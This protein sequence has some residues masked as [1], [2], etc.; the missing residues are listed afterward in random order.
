MEK[1]RRAVFVVTYSK[2]SEGIKYLVLKRKLHWKGWEFPKEGIEGSESEESAVRRGVKEECGLNIT[3]KIQKFDF[4]GKYKYPK[5]Y[6]DRPGFIGQTYSLYACQV[7]PGKIKLDE[8]EHTEARWLSFEQAFKKLRWSTQKK[9]LNIVHNWM[10][11]KDF[12]KIITKSGAL[13]LAG[14]DENTNEKLVMQAG[15]D[16]DVFH[17]S[18]AGSPFVN[19]KGRATENDIHEAALFCAKFSRAWKSSRRDVEVHWFKGKDIYKKKGMKA[20]TFGLRKFKILKLKKEEIEKY[21]L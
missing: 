15:D 6:S 8:H 1:Y 11:G 4:R 21:S 13:L 10:R 17:T 5:V 16:E 12:R 3:G 2:S 19:I 18:M 9:S 20:G 7:I 14:K